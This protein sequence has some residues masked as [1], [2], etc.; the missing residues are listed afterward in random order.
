M[1]IRVTTI[2]VVALLAISAPAA[3]A[4]IAPD[5]VGLQQLTIKHAPALHVAKHK[6][7]KKKTK[8]ST[9]KK[10]KGGS[11][12]K[13]IVVAPLQSPSSSIPDV[14][15]SDCTLYMTNCTTEQL[16]DIWG[17]NCTDVYNAAPLPDAQ[18]APDTSAPAEPAATGSSSGSEQSDASGSGQTGGVAASLASSSAATTDLGY[19]DC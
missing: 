14:S 19:D 17:M 16:C 8:T 1:K 18:P 6:V 12:G 3:F 5:P 2:A 11:A 15:T 7:V 10:N 13:I 4:R 9:N